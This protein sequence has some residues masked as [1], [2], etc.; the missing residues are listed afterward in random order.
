[1]PVQEAPVS[2]DDREQEQQ[3][4]SDLHLAGEAWRV[5]DFDQVVVDKA[6]VVALV[7]SASAQVVLNQRERAR[8]AHELHESAVY[9]DRDMDPDQTGPSPGQEDASDDKGDEQQVDDHHEI[10][11]SFEPHLVTCLD[12]IKPA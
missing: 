9:G 11:A 6:A 5:D 3:A 4:Q 8:E 10:S 1:V 12:S 2:G 7:S